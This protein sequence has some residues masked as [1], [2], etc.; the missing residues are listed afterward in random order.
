MPFYFRKTVSAGPFRLSLS[1]SGIGLSAG[2]RGLRIGTGPRRHYV[3]AG[4]GGIYYR[5]SIGRAGEGRTSTA[6]QNDLRLDPQ[7]YAANSVKMIEVKSGDALDMRDASFGDVLDDIQR[8]TPRIPSAKVVGWCG[9]GLSGLGLLMNPQAGLA[10]LALTLPAWFMARWI[11]SYN[12]RVVLFYD[13]APDC[14]AAYE[15]LTAAFDGLSGC[16]RKWH[17][18]AGGLVTDLTTWKRNAGASHLV[19]RKQTSL[20]YALPRVIASNITPPSMQAGLLMLYFLPDVVLVVNGSTVGAIGYGDLE[21]RWQHSN[22]IEEGQV[23]EDAAIFDYTWRHPNKG[24]GPDRRFRNNHKVP[25]CRYE[26]LHLRSGSGLNALFEFSK[27][28]QCEAF[29]EAVV[30]LGRLNRIKARP[31]HNNAN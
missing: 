27:T 31:P 16:A 3:H 14:Q 23:P 22:F 21:L 29:A 2:V 19:D 30:R 25:V 24:G 10:L 6:Q 8:Q 18:A 5:S 1:K 12:R 15:Q 13:L 17:I 7:E 26:A 9:I 20:N 28:G 4:L 11:D